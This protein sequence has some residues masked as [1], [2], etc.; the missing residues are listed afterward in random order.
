MIADHI[1]FCAVDVIV[2][3]ERLGPMC[4]SS[5]REPAV[6]SAWSLRDTKVRRAGS[7][8][9]ECSFTFICAIQNSFNFIKLEEISDSMA[10]SEEG[11]W[12]EY[13]SWIWLD[14]GIG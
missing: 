8:S 14:V 11:S 7:F 3:L 9:F 2:V 10:L 5:A 12:Y 1:P 6:K 4:H 13:V